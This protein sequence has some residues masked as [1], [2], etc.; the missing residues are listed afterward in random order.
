VDEPFRPTEPFCRQDRDP[1]AAGAPTPTLRASGSEQ[2]GLSLRAVDADLADIAAMIEV[3]TREPFVVAEDVRGRV[4]VDFAGASLDDALKALPLRADKAGSVRLL[5]SNATAAASVPD[6]EEAPPSGRFSM[7]AKRARGEDVIAAMAEAEPAYAALGPSG[8][9]K[10]SVFAREAPIND[11][12]RAA[13]AAL[14]L[15]ETREEN[16]RLLRS[17]GNA[18][19][20]GPIAATTAVRIVFRA[21]DLT[22]DEMALA[23][24]GRSADELVAFVYAPLG[25]IVALRLGD[26]LS[27]GVIAGLDASGVLIDTAEGPVRISLATIRAR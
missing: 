7:R 1:A 15:E 3:L 19:E 2:G 11:V 5:R 18:G 25:E 9:S 27:D 10:L 26:T 17:Q 14:G 16:A 12:R 22:V 23:G 13:L 24:I 8:L 4:S 21:H 20:A 6:A